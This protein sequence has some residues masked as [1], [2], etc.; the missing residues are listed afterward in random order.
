LS[1][2]FVERWREHGTGFDKKADEDAILN[3]VG[4]AV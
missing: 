3:E 1:T 2:A 4:A